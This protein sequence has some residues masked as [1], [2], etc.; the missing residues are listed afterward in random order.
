MRAL[1]LMCVLGSLAACGERISPEQQYSDGSL[2][3]QTFGD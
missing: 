2:G 3:V 1:A